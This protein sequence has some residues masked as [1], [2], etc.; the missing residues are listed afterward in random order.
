MA[1]LTTETVYIISPLYGIDSKRAITT[2]RIRPRSTLVPLKDA[3]KD[4]ALRNGKNILRVPR[5]RAWMYARVLLGYHHGACPQGYQVV[6]DVNRRSIIVPDQ[7]FQFMG[8]MFTVYAS[9]RYTDREVV[10]LLNI[11]GFRTKNGRKMTLS[12][13]RR[14]L[15]NPMYL[16]KV[17]D[18]RRDFD[19]YY[20]GR[21]L[22]A[23]DSETFRK[24]QQVL[25]RRGN[26]YCNIYA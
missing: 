3:A 20:E 22:A 26:C 11:Y 19:Q 10:N 25:K 9:G 21:W 13:L 23:T 15:R 7:N 1:N 14:L 12:K 18:L 8:R 2:P 4:A 17:K 6:K 24:V 5:N 16:G